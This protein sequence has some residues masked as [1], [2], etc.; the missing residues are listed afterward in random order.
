M[1]SPMKAK[2][3]N[4]SFFIILYYVIVLII[5]IIKK[6]LLCRLPEYP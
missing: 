5:Q 1:K 4:V 6:L 3:K 2:S